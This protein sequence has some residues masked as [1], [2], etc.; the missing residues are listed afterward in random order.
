[1]HV[2]L[3][4]GKTVYASR[5]SYPDLFSALQGGS[6]NFGIITQFDLRTFP[7][8]EMLG[9]LVVQ[10][11]STLAAQFAAHIKFMDPKNFDPNATV[12]QAFVWA[13]STGQLISNDIEYS[14]PVLTA[15]AIQPYFDIQPQYLNTER[16][17]NLTD[18]VVELA[19]YQPS[20]ERYVFNINT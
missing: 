14:Q 17:T 18:L 2:V 8:G 12:I 9:G 16:I 11:V 7:H 20:G 1:M 15:P 19:T 13:A 10:P 6:N 3:A 4:G 5:S